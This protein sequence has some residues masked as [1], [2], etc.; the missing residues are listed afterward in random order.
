MSVQDIPYNITAMT[1]DELETAGVFSL[2]DLSRSVPGIAFADLGI[3]SGGVN[4]Q[5]IL[6][7]LNTNAQGGISAFLPNLN[8]AG[9]STYM[10]KHPFVYQFAHE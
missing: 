10:D 8:P 9:V 1:G 5:L 3:R 6:R 4:N 7:G 2:A